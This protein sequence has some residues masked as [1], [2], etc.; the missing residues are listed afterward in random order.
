MRIQRIALLFFVAALALFV[1]ACSGSE[2]TAPAEAAKAASTAPVD[3]AAEAMEAAYELGQE[4]TLKGQLGCGHCN[5]QTGETCSAALQVAEGPVVILDV[6]E[7]HEL[8]TD[9]F[10][11]KQIEVVGTVASVDDAGTHVEVASFTT[12][13]S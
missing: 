13:D 2:P 6:A 12:L 9:R 7:D 10:S 8:F 3:A 5:F 1:S 4:V 11:G